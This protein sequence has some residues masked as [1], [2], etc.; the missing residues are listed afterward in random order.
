MRKSRAER[1]AALQHWADKVRTNDL[2]VAD[3]EALRTIAELRSDATMSMRHSS[4]PCEPGNR[5]CAHWQLAA[6]PRRS[7]SGTE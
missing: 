5:A 2:I 1:V 3:T 6:R 4:M 7:R